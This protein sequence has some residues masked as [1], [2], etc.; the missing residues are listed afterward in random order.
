MT[1]RL[2]WP[3][4][5]I[6]SVQYHQLTWYN[7]FWLWRWLP[8]KLSK[9]HSLLT[10]ALLRTTFT[11]TI[12]LNLLMIIFFLS[13][14]QI[15]AKFKGKLTKNGYLELPVVIASSDDETVIEAQKNAQTKPASQP[16]RRR[17]TFFC[18][19]AQNT[20]FYQQDNSNIDF[21]YQEEADDFIAS[22]LSRTK[23]NGYNFT[24]NSNKSLPR[25]ENHSSAI[26]SRHEPERKFV[27]NNGHF[28]FISA[29]WKLW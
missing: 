9:R 28:K 2:N 26:A 22:L 8:H 29:V 11:W 10:T 19:T 4:R 25:K 21:S 12:K 1:L 15:K 27:N 20:L 18:V 7:S 16:L 23:Q 6:N 17:G 13:V 14:S 3:I 5:S 24:A